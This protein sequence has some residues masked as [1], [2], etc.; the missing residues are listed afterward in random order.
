MTTFYLTFK[1]GTRVTIGVDLI[2]VSRK[3]VEVRSGSRREALQKSTE[4]FGPDGWQLHS[5]EAFT[6]ARRKHYPEGCC[7]I[8]F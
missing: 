2:N 3:W 8:L 1:F 7:L 5:D 4:R 6:P